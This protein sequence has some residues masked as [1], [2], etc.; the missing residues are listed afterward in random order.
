LQLFFIKTF[1]KKDLFRSAI[2]FL[3][4]EK[5]EFGGV[6]GKALSTKVFKIFEEF[7]E[8]FEKFSNKKY[9]PLDPDGKVGLVNYSLTFLLSKF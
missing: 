1:I 4:L 5:V 9:E 8:E 6:K 3:R 2:D 7:K